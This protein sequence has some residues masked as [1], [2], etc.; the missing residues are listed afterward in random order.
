MNHD[1]ASAVLLI[2][3][4]AMAGSGLAIVYTTNRTKTSDRTVATIWTF[5][6]ASIFIGSSI[7]DPASQAAMTYL[8]TAMYVPMS[9]V[10]AGFWM[11]RRF[12]PDPLPLI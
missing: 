7:M 12:P 1:T 5:V 6:F 4:A 8:A 10:L 2:L 11:G 3:A 9:L